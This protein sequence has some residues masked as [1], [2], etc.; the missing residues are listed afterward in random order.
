MVVNVSMI[1][2]TRELILFMGTFTTSLNSVY[3]CRN[4]L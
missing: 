4:G 3:F 2:G 1:K